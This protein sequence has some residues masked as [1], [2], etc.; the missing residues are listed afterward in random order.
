[1]KTWGSLAII[2]VA[3]VS[4]T[5]CA[6][7]APGPA[8]TIAAPVAPSATP[9]PD[10][11]PESIAIAGL[12]F[13]ILFDSGQPAE[14]EYASDPAS[15]IEALTTA[16]GADPEVTVYDEVSCGA[17]FTATAWD[18]FSVFSDSDGLPPGQQFRVFAEK[19]VPLPVAASDGSVLGEDNAAVIAATE[20][21]FVST[22]E[23]KGEGSAYVYFDVQDLTANEELYDDSGPVSDSDDGRFAWGGKTYSK[24]GIVQRISAPELYIDC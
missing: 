7:A 8:E 4:M 5:G 12:S 23:S 2:V 14:F 22:W 21:R 1:M 13:S 11:V 19:S 10:P 9:E 3:A 6:N 17:P 15:A 18:G 24:G 16:F 20:D